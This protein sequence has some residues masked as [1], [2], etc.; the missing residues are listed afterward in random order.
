[1]LL[2]PCVTAR[3]TFTSG[4][5]GAPCPIL[6]GRVL[7]ELVARLG[8][9]EGNRVFL[10]CGLPDAMGGD[11]MQYVLAARAVLVRRLTAGGPEPNP[12]AR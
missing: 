12:S 1:M 10:A 9:D 2:D 11:R 3:A 6:D 8:F 4:S 5:P 7:D